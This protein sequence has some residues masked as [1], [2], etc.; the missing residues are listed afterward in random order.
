MPIVPFFDPATGASGGAP[1]VRPELNPPSTVQPQALAAGSTSLGSTL[2]GS[3]SASVSVS[4]SVQTSDGSPAPTATVSGSGAG[5][6]SVSIASGLANGIAYSITLVGTDGFGQTAETVVTV[7]V[8]SPSGTADLREV[9][10]L[11]GGGYTFTDTFP[12]LSSY[13]FNST[14]K[15]HTFN[16]NT[17]A[18]A[19]EAS[20]YVSGT[21]FTGAKW[22]AAL[23]YADGSPV[24]QGD[25]FAY[26][27]SFEDLTVG[28][29]RGYIFCLGLSQSGTSTSLGTING[30]GGYCGMTAAGTAVIGGWTINS[31]NSNSLTGTWKRGVVS[32]NFSGAPTLL[33]S[34]LAWVATNTTVNGASGTRSSMGQWNLTPTSPLFFCFMVGT[35][36]TATATGGTVT[37]KIKYAVTKLS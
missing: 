9:G 33:N 12:T 7:A 35:L 26:T 21:T 29:T 11:N 24:L 14:T 4:A 8:A 15:V 17:V 31:S 36:G 2:V 37:M 23:T 22:A 25:S 34:G 18:V 13:S 19:N 16:V 10:D 6:Y 32:C 27:V 3:W 5:P 28:A 1:P 20:S 30:T